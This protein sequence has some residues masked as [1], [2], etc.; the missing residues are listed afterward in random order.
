M[1]LLISVSFI[2]QSATQDLFKKVEGISTLF[3]MCHAL[4]DFSAI[5]VWTKPNLQAK[6]YMWKSEVMIK[7][8][9]IELTTKM[10]QH[11]WKMTSAGLVSC[12]FFF[13]LRW[14]GV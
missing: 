2:P 5:A 13:F 4:H 9:E 6:F 1:W 14:V 7:W 10:H 8:T 3:L 11:P 12:C